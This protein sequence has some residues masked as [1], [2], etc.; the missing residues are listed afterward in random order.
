MKRRGARL[1]G[2]GLTVLT[3]VLV[4]LSLV[5]TTER[6]LR[7]TLEFAQRTL[8]GELR[9]GAASGRL[10]GPLVL[11]DVEYR[12][13][14]GVYRSARL[15]LDWAPG[16][17]LTRRL[18]IHALHLDDVDIALAATD[19]EVEHE[20]RES[21]WILPLQ[22]TLSDL[23]VTALRLRRGAAASIVIDNLHAAADSGLEWVDLQTFSVRMAQGE[24]NAQGRIGVGR[25]AASDLAVAWR[26]TLPGYAPLAAQGR[27]S[28]NWNRLELGQQFSAPAAARLELVVEQPFGALRWNAQF[29]TPPLALKDINADWP[30]LRIAGTLRADGNLE[31]YRVALDAHSAGADLPP[32][33]VTASAQGDRAGLRIDA[34]RAQTLDGAVQGQGRVA[35]A[36]HLQWDM[37][38]QA[39]DI[40]PGTH[41]PEWP[42]RL[43]VRLHSGGDTAQ[44]LAWTARIEQLTGDLRGN[45]VRGDGALSMNNDV[46]RIETVQLQSGRARLD[47]DG[48]LADDFDLR[49]GL[50][51]PALGELLPDAAGAVA[52]SGTLTGPRAQPHLRVRAQLRGFALADLRLDELRLDADLSLQ[53]RAALRLSARGKALRIAQRRFDDVSVELDGRLERHTLA[54]RAQGAEHG[55]QLNAR[56]GWDGARWDGRIERADW[57]LPELGAWQLHKPVALRLGQTQGAIERSCWRQTPAQLCAQYD[58]DARERRVRAALTDASLAQ[59]QHG[60]PDTVRIDG[61]ALAAQVDARLPVEGTAQADARI[62]LSAGTLSWQQGDQRQQA[63]FGGATAQVR[64]DERGGHAELRADMSGTDQ[65]SMHVAAPGYALGKAAAQQPLEGRLRGAVRDFSLANGLVESIDELS[66]VLRLDTVLTGTL[67]A[68]QLRGELRLTDGR[69]FIGPAGVQLYDWQM[70]ISEADA[71]GT[72]QLRGSVRSGPGQLRFDGRMK[73]SSAADIGTGIERGIEKGIGKG[74]EADAAPRGLLADLH[75]RGTDFEAVNLPEA[76]VLASPDLRFTLRGRSATIA[77][78]VH[79][80]E[81]RIE[82]R[83]LSGAV[84][85]SRDVV[86]VDAPAP[87]AA[88]GWTVNSRVRLRLGEQVMFKGFGL[89]GRLAGGLDIVDEAGK[90][91]RASGE[92]AIHEGVYSAYAQ[93]LKIERGRA[94]YRDSVLDNPGL[95]VRAT[96]RSGDVLAGVR[97][98]GTVQVPRAEL[99]SQPPLPQA[100]V[101][102]YLVLGRPVAGATGSEGELL[103]KAA[104]SLGLKGGNRLAQS[105]GRRFGIDEVAVAGTEL[106]GAALTLG[107]YLSPRLYLNYSIGLIDA[108]NRLQL[109]YQLTKHVAVQTETGAAAG[110]D[111]VYTIER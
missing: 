50:Q 56:G 37:Q 11:E 98:L 89:H 109:R 35:W 53:P 47:V 107:K 81:A 79:I 64:L 29:S 39:T 46:L 91:P 14:D 108:A 5:A 52:A 12:T 73:G 76:R 86:R 9:W 70:T 87:T 93:E 95:D 18:G 84:T 48:M 27:L 74:T 28:G 16:R 4:A 7:W 69:M 36:P 72:L 42:G 101:L 104:S 1:L 61:G 34:L 103:Y 38:L 57:R 102:S 85:P 31:T 111:V 8:P 26:A 77:G 88:T 105:I 23:R 68:P 99:Y 83:D 17:L 44:G 51:A 43:S 49:W 10:T 54:I 40:D 58:Y 97:V 6:G 32:A 100:D 63:K 62:Q 94:L 60:L 55:V 67:A 22:L 25:D 92:L 96:R 13:S 20:V 65:L 15:Y 2:M 30:E 3:G 24:F 71:D 19:A 59:L 110:G 80:P 66:G 82:P 41:W 75:V 78:K 90:Q 21:G 106:E 33:A 45:P